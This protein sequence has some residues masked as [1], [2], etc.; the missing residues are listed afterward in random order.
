MFNWINKII[1]K[2]EKNDAPFFSWL[3]FFFVIVLFR[4]LLESFSGLGYLGQFLTAASFLH[5][6]VWYASVIIFIT[7]VLSLISKEKIE[8]VS[9][10]V[11]MFFPVIFVS[12]VLPFLINEPVF[13][14]SSYIFAQ[15]W[16]QL[17]ESILGFFFNFH[18]VFYFSIS[19]R[20]EIFLFLLLSAI[21]VFAKTKNLFKSL[22][23]AI[24]C[25]LIIMF[26]GSLPSFIVI[27]QNP[28]FLHP[29]ASFL[30]LFYNN[31]NYLFAG[32]NYFQSL[33]SPSYNFWFD[34]LASSVFF[35]IFI[36]GLLFSFF[37]YNKNLL[38]T[39]FKNFRW[40]RGAAY[41]I[42]SFIGIAVA[43]KYQGALIQLNFVNIFCLID[44]VL[45]AFLFHLATIFHNDIYDYKIDAVSNQN[46]PLPSGAMN[47]DQF[48]FFAVVFSLL[49]LIGALILN[50]YFFILVLAS[51]GLAFLYSSPPLRLKKIFLLN[52]FLIAL[53]YL[54]FVM[55]GFFV[56]LPTAT[57]NDFPINIAVLTVLAVFLAGNF[58]DVKDFKGDKEQSIATIP[59]LFGLEKGKKIIGALLFVSAIIFPMFLKISA[60]Y[61]PAIIFGLIFYWLASKK[62]YSEKSIFLAYLCYLFLVVI[63][64]IF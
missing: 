9:K 36:L 1:D 53:A 64:V 27:F 43:W 26:F 48:K 58:K 4:F 41:V 16:K 54:F 5:F 40:E 6:F 47:F 56:A 44:L 18:T 49:S 62:N 23:A 46:R 2:I 19:I 55:G 8:N 12:V 28:L 35:P 24:F 17:F 15:N 51:L 30:N 31:F 20:I 3:A 37:L 39:V 52:T 38:K 13:G 21:Y 29:T 45:S 33:S 61:F 32:H 63:A 10:S 11:L 14:S 7:I 22:L 60:L 50:F 59:S 57:V 42:M 25:Y 34:L